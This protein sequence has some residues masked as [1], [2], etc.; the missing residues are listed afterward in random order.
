LPAAAGAAPWP[1]A[2][3]AIKSAIRAGSAIRIFI[4]SDSFN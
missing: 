1:Q 3:D 2:T 4:S